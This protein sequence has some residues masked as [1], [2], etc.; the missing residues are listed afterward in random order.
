MNGFSGRK[1]P[2]AAGSFRRVSARTRL[3]LAGGGLAV[4]IAAAAAAQRP[5][6]QPVLAIH[7]GIP[8]GVAPEIPRLRRQ[9][10][11]RPAAALSTPPRNPFAFN[12]NDGR[13]FATPSATLDMLRPVAVAPPPPPLPQLIGILSDATADGPRYRAV[14][15]TAQGDLWF[16]GEGES[17]DGITVRHLT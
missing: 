1:G 2:A 11:W 17:R 13:Q 12:E 15:V 4:L 16:A 8:I 5:D 10:P 14:L 6:G 3:A 9:W 7:T